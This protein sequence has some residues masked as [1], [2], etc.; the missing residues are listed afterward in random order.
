MRTTTFKKNIYSFTVIYEADSDG[1]YVAH[2]PALA[3]CHTQGESLEET[4]ANVKEAIAVYLE[5]L[6]ANK[7]KVP[8]ERRILQGKVEVQ[9]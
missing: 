8:S 4:E 3:G 7:E 2:V 9:V 1:G 5:S 6:V